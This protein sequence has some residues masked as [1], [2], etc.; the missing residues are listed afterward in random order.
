[1]SPVGGVTVLFGYGRQI[2]NARCRDQNGSCIVFKGFVDETLTEEGI[3]SKFSNVIWVADSKT[4]K[5]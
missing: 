4:I 1:M 5:I 3:E 2:I